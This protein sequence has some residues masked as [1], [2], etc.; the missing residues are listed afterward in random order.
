MG[1]KGFNQNNPKF[2][3]F[4]TR[5]PGGDSTGIDA[6]SEFNAPFEASGGLTYTPGNGYKYHVF[7]SNDDFISSGP[8]PASLEVLLVG[9][10]GGGGDGGG[11]N[12]GGGGAG[13]VRYYPGFTIT[14]GTHPVIIGQGGNGA[15]A[16]DSDGTRGGDTTAFGKTATGGGHNNYNDDTLG[17]GGSGAGTC[18]NADAGTGNAGGNDPDANPISEGNAG[19]SGGGGGAA[20]AAQPGNGGNGL[21]FPQFAGP[22]IGQ[23]GLNPH[24]GYFGGGGGSGYE[25]VN[26]TPGGLGGGGHGASRTSGNGSVAT[27]G[28]D[29]LGGGGGGTSTSSTTPALPGGDGICVVR[30]Q[31][32]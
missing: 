28:V 32:S 10:G 19:S 8:S 25:S 23:P 6:A 30:Y 14:S 17:N 26:S 18:Y 15:P 9:G 7:T 12:G 27:A 11:G 24:N 13:G 21:Q 4:F 1:I 2:R 31:T 5:A 3:N 29:M 16:Y 20:Q 22:L